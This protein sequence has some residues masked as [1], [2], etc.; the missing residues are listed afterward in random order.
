MADDL[1]WWRVNSQLGCSPIRTFKF[2]LEMSSDASLTGW[3]VH[4]QGIS[5]QG[6][7]TQKEKK[8]SINYLELLAAFLHSNVLRLR[9]LI[10]KSY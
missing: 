1:A 6:F 2:S 3:G 7:W 5:S 4:C 10:A 9:T 8:F